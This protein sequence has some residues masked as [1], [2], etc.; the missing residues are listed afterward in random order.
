MLVAFALALSL[1]GTAPIAR[2]ADALDPAALAARHG[3]RADDFGFVLFDPASGQVIA[4]HRADAPFI[5]AS[6]TKVATALAVLET[7]GPDFRFATTLHATGTVRDGAL[8][9][10]LHLRGGGDPTLDGKALRALV[11]ALGRAGIT[12][13]DGSLLV[14]DTL[15]PPAA[16]IDPRQPEAATYNPAVGALAVNFNRIELR[17]RR[18]A[19]RSGFVTTITSPSAGGSVP[20]T[21][22][23]TDVL[24]GQVDP[25]IEFVFAPSPTPRWLLSPRLPA[26]GSVFLPVKTDP[27]LLAAELLTTLASR[28]GMTLP[29]ARL[30]PVPP[31]ARE[32]ARVES[33][34]LV[35]IVEGMLRYSNNLTAELVGLAASRR[36]AGAGL[37]LPA[38]AELLARWWQERLP[39]TSFRGFV[40]ANHSGLSATTRH[41]PRQLAAILH[42]GGSSQAAVLAELL[43][44]WAPADDA[45]APAVRAKSGTLHYADG[46]VGFLRAPDGRGR[47]FVILLTDESRRRQLDAARDLRVAA[48]PP[49]AV[50]W[51]ARAKALERELVQ[52][53]TADEAVA[54]ARVR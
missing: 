47:G 10:A 53:W 21:G 15:Y 37:A 5:P 27:G 9:G 26:R 46:L 2:A 16:E 40:A 18:E 31:E 24:D 19:D 44:P 49:A 33:E 41:T 48:S 4:E 13:V 12:R 23:A 3:F 11:A 32:I 42:H 6:T 51:T 43:A 39:D 7:L 54:S 38:S 22:L 14:D 29:G 28:A 34:P 45:P 36:L 50:S 30:G 1:L 52:R 17:W 25:R 35:E 20:V 8:D